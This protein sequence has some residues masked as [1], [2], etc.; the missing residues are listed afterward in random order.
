MELLRWL[1]EDADRAF[2]LGFG[3]CLLILAIGVSV[4]IARGR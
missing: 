1:G 2:G 4:R 3:M